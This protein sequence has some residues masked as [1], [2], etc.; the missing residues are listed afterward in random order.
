[1]KICP[2]CAEEILPA[3]IVCKHCRRDLVPPV[4]STPAP[5][6]VRRRV[7]ATRILAGMAVLVLGLFG[8]GFYVYATSA[9]SVDLE[10]ATKVVAIFQGPGTLADLRCG[11][12]TQA[13]FK[14]ATWRALGSTHQQTFMGAL[15]RYCMARGGGMVVRL[16]D[17]QQRGLAFSNGWTVTDH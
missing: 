8:F 15:G 1:M 5:P 13:T 16:V 11:H 14:R 10:A 4:A 9:A 12:P 7:P 2:F 6:P 3:A 17:E